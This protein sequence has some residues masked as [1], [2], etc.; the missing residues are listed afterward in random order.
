M[1]I[2]KYPGILRSK[3]V[4]ELGKARRKLRRAEFLK[5]KCCVICKSAE[6]LEVDHIDPT[7]KSIEIKSLWS[8]RE[9]IRVHELKKCQVLCRKCHD[10]KN[11]IDRRYW[12][13]ESLKYGYNHNSKKLTVDQVCKIKNDLREIG[14]KH[15]TISKKYG[16]TH[17]TIQKIHYGLIWKD[18]K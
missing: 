16:V 4:S 12:K 14:P 1:R 7:L 10:K 15:K 13:N 8:Y 3:R 2:A 6:R 9:S 18:I 5:G 11:V 17:Y